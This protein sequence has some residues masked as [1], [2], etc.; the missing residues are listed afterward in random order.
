MDA[1][2]ANHEFE[3]ARFFSNEER[4]ERANLEELNKKYKFD[5]NPA[6][7][8]RSEEIQRAVSKLTGTPIDSVL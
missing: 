1:A 6:F 8:I 2:I 3:K 7:T 5:E 4:K